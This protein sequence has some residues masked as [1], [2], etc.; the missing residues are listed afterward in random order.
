MKRRF[1][2]IG[3]F[4]SSVVSSIEDKNGVPKKQRLSASTKSD[5]TLLV[6]I[7]SLR[8]FLQE[9]SRAAASATNEA[10]ALGLSGFSVG[11]QVFEPENDNV[12]RG[13]RLAQGLWS[14]IQ[15]Q[16]IK[17][18]M[19]SEKTLTNLIERLYG[20]AKEPKELDRYWEPQD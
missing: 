12:M 10:V 8:H 19:N 14:Q 15:D 5:I 11:Q 16:R 20:I 3:S 13:E 1:D 7:F 17:N 9:G 4:V 18:L 6:F 2:S